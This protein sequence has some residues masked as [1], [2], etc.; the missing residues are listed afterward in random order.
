MVEGSLALR[1]PLVLSVDAGQLSQGC[2]DPAEVFHES[3]VIRG[4]SQEAAEFLSVGRCL[5][6]VD[7][8]YFG[9]VDSDAILGDPM[10]QV[11]DLACAELTLG[12]VQLEIGGD[13]ALEH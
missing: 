5:K 12:H 2:G 7:G 1:C 9:W 8:F 11:D 13:D 4:H 3:L 10:A 6:S